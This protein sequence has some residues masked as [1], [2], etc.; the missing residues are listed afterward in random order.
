MK[1]LVNCKSD[2]ISCTHSEDVSQTEYRSHTAPCCNL[3]QLGH[4]KHGISSKEVLN[5]WPFVVC[6]LAGLSKIQLVRFS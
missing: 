5:S 6:L 1:S 2:F 3:E 4:K